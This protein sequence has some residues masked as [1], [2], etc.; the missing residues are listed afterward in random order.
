MKKKI[1]L[2][3]ILTIVL[4]LS[5]LVGATYALFTSTKQVN[6]AITAGKLDVVATIDPALKTW[7]LGQT[8]TNARTDGSFVNGGVA[9]I[10]DG[11]LIIKRMTPGDVVKFTIKVENDSDVAL[12][13]RV[14]AVSTI[15]QDATKDLS[16]AL[17]T[18][19]TVKGTDYQMNTDG[20]ECVSGWF[21]VEAPDGNGADITDITVIVRF[22]NGTPE[23]DNEFKAAGA[24]ITFTVEA[25]Q[26][27]G[28]DAGG[29]IIGQ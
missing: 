17:T 15:A 11:K 13:Y 10:E 24:S 3:S 19:A 4:C 14:K 27:N 21:L 8:E 18:V 1:L 12:K 20:K 2:S 28:V 9:A 23:H 29:N 25:V 6:V 5:I 22:P 7:S 16:D 26:S